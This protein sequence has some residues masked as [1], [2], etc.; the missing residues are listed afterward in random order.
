LARGQV[1]IIPPGRRFPALF[2]RAGGLG[3]DEPPFREHDAPQV[4][5][6]A[7]RRVAVLGGGVG[8]VVTAFALTNT[9]ELRSRFSVTLYQRGWRLGG[10]GASGRNADI[11]QRIEEHGLHIWF[12]FYDNAFRLMRECYEELG[13]PP[14]TPL[15]T[16]EDAFHPASVTVLFDKQGNEWVSHEQRTPSNPLQPGES[17]DMPSFWKIVEQ[18]IGM[19]A[20]RHAEVAGNPTPSKAPGCMPKLLSDV[21][22]FLRPVERLAV[23]ASRVIA[24][25]AGELER[26]PHHEGL[27]CRLLEDL[28]HVVWVELSEPRVASD[29]DVRFYWT[30]VDMFVSIMLGILRDGVLDDGFDAINDVEFSAWL[31]RHGA[32]ALTIGILPEMRAPVLRGSYD[33]AF[34]FEAG[35]LTQAT[36]AAGTAVHIML[37]WLF[38]YHGAFYYKMCSGMGDTVFAPYYEVLRRR[39][40][41][42][43]FFHW[44]TRLGV[45]GDAMRISEIDVVPQVD[46]T[47]DAYEPLVD[48][49]GLPCWPN[50]PVWCQ[51]KD[52]EKLK[53][54]HVDFDTTSNPLNQTTKTLR[55]GE[56]FDDVVLAIPVGALPAICDELIK[57]ARNPKFRTM[58]ESSRTV[59]TQAFQLWLREDSEHLGWKAG[60][61]SIS[62][63]YVEPLDTYSDMTQVLTTETW[64]SDSEV[65][66]IAYMCGVLDDREGE[67]AEQSAARAKENAFEYVRTNTGAIWPKAVGPDGALPY[68]LLAVIDDK[69]QGKARFDAQ[70]FR[71]N[72]DTSERYVLSPPSLISHRLAADESGYDNL[73]LAGDWTR[74]GLD[75]GCVE[76]ATMS[77][78]QA[79][80]ALIGEGVKVVGEDDSWIKR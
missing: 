52:G 42:I 61:W 80:R 10:K 57:D 8:G 73:F 22:H 45:D 63:T 36:V 54:D 37:R 50:E 16:L 12:G 76:A 60:M 31:A 64:P 21:W 66:S 27:L 53:S 43:Q 19:L 74:N 65:K 49:A 71:A 78:L 7:P 1:P 47:V 3:L 17:L 77:G 33:A 2:R 69:I 62:G 79:A 11:G 25:L 72:V 40:V 46:L 9:E 28:R 67:T 5:E 56:D 30:S 4:G 14:G 35:Q 13:R 58:I 51:L 23:D 18:G 24:K 44:A 20:W 39:G 55:V 38:T 48:V 41:D 75:A 32:S 34:A 15:A 26:A 70:Y 59:A 68:D 6:E 29:P